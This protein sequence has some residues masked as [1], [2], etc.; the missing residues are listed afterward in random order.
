LTVAIGKEEE[1]SRIRI[2]HNMEK[3]RLGTRRSV[4]LYLE[5]RALGRLPERI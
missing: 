5:E 2:E 4:I 3:R 1:S